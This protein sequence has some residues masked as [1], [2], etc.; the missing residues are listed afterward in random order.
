MAAR[1]PRGPRAPLQ[2]QRDRCLAG[3]HGR[4]PMPSATH[5]EVPGER[6]R[7]RTAIG[8][9]GT[10]NVRTWGHRRY[11]A[12]TRFRDLDG[13]LREVTATAGSRTATRPSTAGRRPP[14]DGPM[15][16]SCSANGAPAA[17]AG[18]CGGAS[19]GVS[20]I[21]TS[22]RSTDETAS[23]SSPTVRHPGCSGI[24]PVAWVA[25]TPRSAY[26]V[27]ERSRIAR[28]PRTGPESDRTGD[29]IWLISCLFVERQQRRW[30]ATSPRRVR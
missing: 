11:V 2:T 4:G 28:L 17:D 23:Y 5:V 30:S 15:S 12:R 18:A 3:V 19:P 14:G 10:I 7:P 26:P 25:P 16:S 8:T 6:G 21:Q 24:S 27:A 29:D 13:R 22:V 20:S 9:Y 1:L